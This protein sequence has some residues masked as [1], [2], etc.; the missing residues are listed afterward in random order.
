VKTLYVIHH[1]HTDIGYTELQGRVARRHADFIRQALA[2][3]EKSAGRRSRHFTGF[4]WQCETFWGVEK[5]L[6]EATGDERTAFVEAVRS[7]AIGVSGS[8]LN[9]NE[10]LDYDL[11]LT[12]TGRAAD[13]GRSI[14]VPVD[15]AMTAD[16]NGYS[17]GFSQAL[18]DRGIENLF[19][20]I[21]THH[22]M[23]PFGRTQVPFWWETPN[24]DRVLV[25]SGEHYHFG[26]E[27]GIVPGAVS[28]YVTKDECDAGMIFGDHWSV[29]EIRI[30]RYVERLA[31][32]G[33]PYDVVPVMASGLRTDNAPPCPL[34]IDFVERWNSEHGSEIRV[35]M[36]TLSAFFRHLRERRYDFPVHRGDWP[37]WWS[38][39]PSGN[40]ASTK[41]FRNAQR[42]L[43]YYHALTDRYTE[44][45]PSD[46][47][48]I[49]SDLIHYAEHTF[50]YANSVRD[51]WY[52]MV[53]AI[54]ERKKAYAAVA[55]DGVETALD[56]ALG[57]LGAA[58]LAVGTPL[59]Y[60]VVNPL[61]RAVS[62][63]A[64][65]AVGHYELNELGL[66]RGAEVLDVE[67]GEALPCELRN[68]PFGGEFCVPVRLAP[69]EERS[70][71]IRATDR[72][73]Y[74]ARLLDGVEAIE[75]PFVRIAWRPG[76]GIVGWRDVVLGRELLRGELSHAPFTPVHEVTPVA[77]QEGICTVRGDMGLNRKGTDAVRSPGCFVGA[78]GVRSGRVFAGATLEYGVPGLSTYVVELRAHV[79]EPRVD[80]AVRFHKDSVWEPENVYLSLPFTTGTGGETLW[81]DK[82]GAPVRPR[83]DQLPGTLTDFY[84]I[85]EGLALTAR[86]RGVAV[87]TPDSHL[88]QL[89]ALEHGVRPLA[90]DPVLDDD[91][92][93]VYAWLMTN[94]WETNF[95]ADLGG[96]YEFR[97]T[98]KWGAGLADPREAL[99]DCR[100]TNHGIVSFRLR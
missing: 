93:H 34:I 9:L 80:V 20:C 60:S 39:G 61:H 58:G 30:P 24:G 17:W 90:G 33:Y 85:Q 32:G 87:A 47:S 1:S 4:R 51:P 84:S 10:L 31:D 42:R 16:I 68:T 77:D 12:A 75:T 57:M 40:A 27:L 82:A 74:E 70:L 28:S 54:S 29:A 3:I 65:L 63:A 6:E 44:L 69:G 91:P 55:H 98:V 35:E 86:D 83:V 23:Y 13:F 21:H 92:A 14:D 78:Q 19:T 26:N 18:H 48:E 8:Y 62:G 56:A 71:E 46:V 45:E 41:L 79:A 5:F 89:G 7:G 49:E 36:T 88:V 52:P 94:Y 81:L 76:D 53:H 66:D 99:E 50:S 38:D 59:T 37:D 43:A 22:G 11:L 25:W 72:V 73:E 100:A 95:S 15:S 67:S 96:F 2:I 97:Y 64:Y